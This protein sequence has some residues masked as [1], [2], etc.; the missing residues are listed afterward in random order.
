MGVKQRTV[1]QISVFRYPF[2]DDSCLLYWKN[3]QKSEIIGEKVNA[4]T[5][6]KTAEMGEVFFEQKWS[7]LFVKKSVQ[8]RLKTTEMR[9]VFLNKKGRYF[10]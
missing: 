5:L 3:K 7:I 1:F 4:K 2:F 9:E 6:K 10:C 8:K